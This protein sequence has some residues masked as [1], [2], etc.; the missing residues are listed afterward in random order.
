[1]N[2]LIGFTISRNKID[3]NDIDIFKVDLK[4]IHFERN[5]LNIYLWGIGEIAKC[6]I[7][8]KYSLYFPINTNLL[9]RNVLIS[10]DNNNIIIEN[11]WLGSIPI[12]YNGKELIIS[13]L[14]LKVLIKNSKNIHPE[15]LNNYFEF[16][17]SILDQT[18]FTDVKFMRYFSKLIINSNEIKIEDK[19]D[20]IL[21]YELFDKIEDE[22]IVLEKIQDYISNVENQTKSEIILP[23]SGGYD[24]RLLNICINDKSR[25]RSFTYGTS[26]DQSKSFEVI[27][28][29]KISELLRTK[30][31]Q[32]ELEDYNK[33][34]NEWFKIYGFSTHFHGMYHI[35]FYKKILEQNNFD[36]NATFLSG[37][38]GDAWSG[39]VE[40]KEINNYEDLVNIGYTHGIGMNRNYC[41][42][43][44]NDTIK[45]NFISKN[46]KVLKNKKMQIIFSMRFKLMLLSY[47][48]QI[49]EYFG[50]PVWTPF[51]N[52]DIATSMLN[53]SEERRENRIWQKEFFAKD[54]FDFESMNLRVKRS[55]TLDY[56]ASRN[57]CFEPINVELIQKYVER[58]Y[59]AQINEKLQ[60]R[61]FFD[62]IKNKILTMRY[63]A[64][65]SR[66]I[67]LKNDFLENLL[68]YYII[69]PIEMS[70]KE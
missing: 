64:K 70:L 10:F 60:N 56:D 31:K 27:Y 24:T 30:W 7:N 36:K 34:L 14:P 38:I 8:G 63:V 11:D 3:H 19:N 48:T 40:L 35:E 54:G 53:I 45:K 22:K 20:P 26:K 5:G 1:M 29:K 52:F 66:M 37:I 69:K 59:L 25:I 21:Q 55:N 43:S 12:F 44:S 2:K 4:Q 13:T 28:A 23:T 49:P 50:F 16:G 61:I 17:Y 42:L 39:N 51:L 15:G 18:P 62:D 33:Y 32:I 67:G 9:D 68:L 47:L 57:F 58:D 65:I 41:K 46:I 6:I